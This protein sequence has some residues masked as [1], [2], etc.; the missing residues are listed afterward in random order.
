MLEDFYK[1][2]DIPEVLGKDILLPESPLDAIYLSER[3]RLF[4]YL[5]IC[6]ID[7]DRRNML[8]SWPYYMEDQPYSKFSEKILGMYRLDNG[9]L[10]LSK[11]LD[12][13][14]CKEVKFKKLSEY[15]VRL[16]NVETYYCVNKCYDTSDGG[17]DFSEDEDLTRA[18][19]GLTFSELSEV[20]SAYA[21]IFGVHNDY[22]QYPRITRSTKSDNFCDITEAWIPESFPYITFSGSGYAY[23]H[24][25]LHGFY[26][27][28]G[29]LFAN[30]SKAAKYFEETLSNKEL[31]ERLRSV[32]NDSKFDS[33]VTRTL[34]YPEA[35]GAKIS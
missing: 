13:G 33:V 12:D 10:H 32:I 6:Q 19:F 5:G 25:S 29:A 23:S 2:L 24:V 34:M 1:S 28:I 16:P 14:F 35:W 21:K 26:Q 20:L 3:G 7:E 8:Q 27:H 31:I 9:T 17:R 30:G 22:V 15:H 11:F 18:C 4:C